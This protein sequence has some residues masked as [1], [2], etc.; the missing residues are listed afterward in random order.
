MGAR[1]VSPSDTV[2]RLADRI[3]ERFVGER[4]HSCTTRHPGIADLDLTGQRLRGTDSVGRHLLLH[5]DDVTV[6]G[7]VGMNGRWTAGPRATEP[8]WRRR[9]ELRF[10]TGWLTA[11]DIAV[12][13]AVARETR[14]T[15]TAAPARRAGYVVPTWPTGAT[16][17]GDAPH[18]PTRAASR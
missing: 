1:C 16:A 4:V 3:S 6:H 13:D 10:D 9:L 5:F 11:L 2:V 18:A 8:E 12:L 17:R 7:H 15:S 14:A